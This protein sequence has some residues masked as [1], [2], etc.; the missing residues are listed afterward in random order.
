MNK[1]IICILF[2]ANIFCIEFFWDLGVGISSKPAKS[3]NNEIHISTYHRLEGMKKYFA[4][5]YETAIYHFSQL[6]EYN[7]TIVLYEYID[8]YYLL[9]KFSDAIS[10]LNNYDNSELSENVIYLKSKIYFK[11]NLFEKSLID[12]KYLLD[13][14]ENSDY[15]NILK[16]EIQKI[17]L[18]KDE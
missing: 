2:F 10:I 4:M 16:F 1:Y 15:A 6:D 12:I 7:Q 11:L 9:N 5:D 14:Y 13:N 3:V 8:C 18:L 17:N